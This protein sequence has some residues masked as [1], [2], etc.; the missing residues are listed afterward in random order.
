MAS[1]CGY[2]PK[3]SLVGTEVETE[4]LRVIVKD[5]LDTVVQFL[6]L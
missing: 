4:R 3:D 6:I 1:G 5:V 2:L